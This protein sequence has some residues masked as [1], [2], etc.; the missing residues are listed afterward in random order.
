VITGVLGCLEVYA[1]QLI[2]PDYRNF[3][4]QDTAF[5]SAAGRAGGPWMFHL[6]NFTLL[7]ATMGSSL[8]AQLGS[9]RLLFAMGRDG[10][11]PRGFFGYLD[12]VSHTPRYNLYLT[13]A[14]IAL[15]GLTMTYQSGAE[16]LNFGA[17]IAFMG[18][19]L[20]SLTR[21]YLRAEDRGLRSTLVNLLPPLLGL[22]VCLYIWLSLR[23]SAKLI[24]AGWLV[25]GGTYYWWLTR[26]LRRPISLSDVG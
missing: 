22:V 12:P 18:V 14:V 6:M 26:G 15:G 10:V 5:V 8:G 9:V 2:W 19:N 7:V 11:L 20:S 3:P 17:F 13:G 4:D 21:Y 16:L 1:G 23:T 25:A 24:G